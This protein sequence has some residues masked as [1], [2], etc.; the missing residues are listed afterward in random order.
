[1]TNDD[2]TPAPSDIP[3][4]ENPADVST[5]IDLARRRRTQAR[6][7][8]D[9]YRASAWFATRVAAEDIDGTGRTPTAAELS[10]EGKRSGRYA[11]HLRIPPMETLLQ[12]RQSVDGRQHAEIAL[13]QRDRGFVRRAGGRAKSEGH[14]HN[15]DQRCGKD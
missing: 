2:L 9:D 7:L 11:L 5:L 8:G 13:V 12:A 14:A 15:Q 6:A 3:V 10:A 1:M 4:K